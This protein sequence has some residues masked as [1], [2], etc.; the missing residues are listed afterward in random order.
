MRRCIIV[1]LLMGV[2]FVLMTAS[3]LFAAPSPFDP[4]AAKPPVAE[5]PAPAPAEATPA[6]ASPT[7]APPAPGHL[8]VPPKVKA[9]K[10]PAKDNP[11]R[12]IRGKLTP[13]ER[14]LEAVLLERAMELKV[15]VPVDPKTGAFEVRGLR[16]GTYD[17]VVRT[18]W[19]RLEGIDMTPRVSDYDALVPPE[20]RTD[21]LVGGAGGPF[22]DD[23]RK[24][25]RR[26]ITE[27]KRYENKVRDVYLSGS[28]DKAVALVELLM[29][30]D[31]H[32]R[33][34]D[35]VTW[36]IE[37]WYYEKKY[38]AWTAFRTRCLYRFR[39]KQAAWA[40]WGWQ[41]EPALGGFDITPDRKEPVVVEF[42]IPEK[43]TPEKGLTGTKA[44]PV[45][46][47]KFTEPRPADEP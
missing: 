46:Q 12:T 18:P 20:Y 6:A 43:P 14:V 40:S 25:V 26:I 22:T 36:R 45:E 32:S 16:L 23:D 11:G 42:A 2:G 47:G 8:P 35:E 21:E 3:A 38:D 17:L 41:F 27:V 29:D 10:I 19:G 13:P 24:A 4:P 15:P 7:P 5:A 1:G 37:Q 28:A 31:F 33:K 9:E 44:P 30:A 39:V 34:G